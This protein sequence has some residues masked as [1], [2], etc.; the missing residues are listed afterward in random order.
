MFCNVQEIVETLKNAK[1]H[2]KKCSVL[3]GAG[4]SV[5]AGI[6]TA[7]G[8]VEIIRE[9]FPNKY[10]KAEEKTYAKC[11]AQLADSEQHDLIA[12]FVD[13]SKINWAHI[14]LTQLMKNGYVDRV[15]TTNFDQ[16]VLRACTLSRIYP[17]I[18]DVAASQL[19]KRGKVPDHA[20]FHLHGQR[21]GFV[22][23]NTEEAF[24]RHSKLL[25][26]I[27]EDA[28]VERVWI[29]VGYSGQNDPVFDHLARVKRFDNNLYWVGYKDNDPP[30]HLRDTLLTGGKYAFYLKG[31]DAD[32]FFVT[33]AQE[34][35]CFPPDYI[36]KP[37]SYLEDLYDVLTPYV[38]PRTDVP[39]DNLK[40]ARTFV[41]DAIDKMEGIHSAVLQAWYDLMAGRHEEVIALRSK[42]AGAM[43][44]EM[45]DVISWAYV[46]QGNQ[47]YLNGLEK[48]GGEADGLYKEACEK[49]AEAV[50]IKPDMHEAFYN[51]GTALYS[52]AK[53]KAGGEADGLYKEACE[54]YAEAVKIKPEDH[55]AFNNWGNALY[56]W[57]QGRAGGEADGL[58]KE[59]CEKYAEAVK[60][61][62][63]MH[64][65]FNNWGNAL[66]WWYRIVSEE[67]KAEIL[68]QARDVLLETEK[69]LEGRGSYGL[70]C[71]YALSGNEEECRRWLIKSKDKGELP[72]L[73]H[74]Q[75]DSD[76]DSVRETQWFKEFLD[77]V[78]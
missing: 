12:E 43:H 1:E 44:P 5:T 26:P 65:A 4:C 53:G 72:T 37:F 38:F 63:D 42:Y 18:Y 47:S 51:W 69:I 55:E 48:A 39:V 67:R 40:F 56:S 11:M 20:V 7:Q 60:I 29:V 8:F 22:L 45:I 77:D 58:Y 27:F 64:E 30:A 62:P 71:V 75:E 24:Q 46:D 34:L 59:A 16:L 2:G 68:K 41:R 32:S 13:N 21:T 14:A 10:E 36:R 49:Y 6:P 76:L 23:I 15:L 57:A 31:F 50:K 66:L 61:R 28:G 54:K 73:E 35:K 52:W 25:K 74:L 9:R 70:A 3:I 17:A 33:L 19:F 78:S